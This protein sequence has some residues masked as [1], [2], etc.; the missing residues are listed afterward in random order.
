MSSQPPQPL[1]WSELFQPKHAGTDSLV[2]FLAVSQLLAAEAS[3]VLE[4]GCG[5]GAAVDTNRRRPMGDFRGPGR[6]V[7]GIDVDDAGKQNEVVDEFRQIGPDGRWP[8]ED[9][10][11]DLAVSDWT[12]EHVADPD[13]FV[14]EL[15]RVL[16]P[17]GAF[18][19]RTVSRHS[20]L[21]WIART[22]P[23]DQHA[24][25]LA[26]F[27]HSRA[28]RD[29]FP[30]TYRMNTDRDLAR[31]F[32]PGFE[33]AVAHRTG[34]RQYVLAWPRLARSVGALEPHLPRGL[35]MALVVYARK[36]AD[37]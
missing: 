4:V 22:V 35:Q 23:D 32:G 30:T 31:L 2:P 15:H 37:Q 36:L 10:S 12:L 17:G 18:V 11:I 21:S 29:V 19:A 27:R 14:R 3:T 16:R 24:S 1:G 9:A 20:P 26:R 6:R 33:W 28:A 34:L 25:V 8:V 7:I 5:R 13:G